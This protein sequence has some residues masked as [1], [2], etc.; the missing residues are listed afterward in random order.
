MTTTQVTSNQPIKPVNG[1]VAEPTI[2][3]LKARIAEL[4]NAATAAVTYKCRAA[5][6][7]YTDGQ[8]KEQ[9]GKGVLSMYGLG[10]FPVSLFDSQWKRVIS[11]VKSGRLEAMLVAN[12]AKLAHKG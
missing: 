10:K 4:E 3:E 1:G 5:G 2:A 11:E 6:E 12:A 8:G 7:K 9:I